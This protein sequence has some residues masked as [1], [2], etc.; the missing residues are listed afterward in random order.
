MTRAR[1]QTDDLMQLAIGIV[2]DCPD[3]AFLVATDGTIVAWNTPASELFGI[4]T[5]DASAHNCGAIV[6]GFSQSGEPICRAG[7]PLLTGREPAPP[8][9]AMRVRSGLLDSVRAVNVHH[10]PI[11]DAMLGT[12][13]AVLHLVDPR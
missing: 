7:C 9:T 5:W 10:L 1:L 13:I 8:S 3:A 2:G 12:T 4:A 6:H 11:R